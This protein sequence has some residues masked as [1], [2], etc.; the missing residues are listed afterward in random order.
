M[1]RVIRRVGGLEEPAGLQA[2]RMRVI[3]RVG[4]L[5]VWAPPGKDHLQ[6]IHGVCAK[7][8]C[9]INNILKYGC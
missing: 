6:N 7:R 1:V 2:H 3:R 9:V 5:E 8:E 4:G